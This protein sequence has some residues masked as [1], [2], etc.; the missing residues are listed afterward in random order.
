MAY[1]HIHT[2]TLRIKLQKP[3]IFSLVLYILLLHPISLIFALILITFVCLLM[4]G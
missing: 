2:Y 4:E 1:I 3:H